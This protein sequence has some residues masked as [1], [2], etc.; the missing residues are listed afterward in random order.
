MTIQDISSL[1]IAIG[2]S[3]YQEL[4]RGNLSVSIADSIYNLSPVVK[5]SLTDSY[6][7]YL[8]SRIGN[9]GTP[10][11]LK[12]TAYGI[13]IEYPL[14][15]ESF[16]IT[17]SSET[18]K[19]LGGSY[20]AT[21]LH[22]FMF[23]SSEVKAYKNKSASSLISS[24]FSDFTFNG[25][26]YDYSSS[27]NLDMD[28]IYNPGYTPVE[29]IDKILLPLSSPTTDNINNPYYIFIDAQN[30]L[31]YISLNTMLQRGAVNTLEI[32]NLESFSSDDGKKKYSPKN[33]SLVA[34][35]APFSQMY[36][37]IFNMIDTVTCRVEN[38]EYSTVDSSLK[39]IAGS[40][41]PFYDRKKSL[42]RY[43]SDKDFQTTDEMMRLQAGI[44]YR[45]RASYMLD[46]IVVTT[47]LNLDLCAG[48]MVNLNSYFSN[49]GE[50]TAK[51]YT[52]KYLI[53]SSV[54][55]WDSGYNTGVSQLVLATPT[56]S[57]EQTSLEGH[58]YTGE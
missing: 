10:W 24:L 46:K 29:F 2:D 5:V 53:E 19:G 26:E 52:G 1:Q 41:M 9:Y 43:M 15:A 17:S 20:S 28:F 21:L 35:S 40:K 3:D 13:P 39:K 6:G 7:L 11:K 57:V 30:R 32:S 55:K 42:V 56:P 58:V 47:L 45:N 25:S 4:D 38:G 27:S 50:T 12:L 49:L 44:N 36:S 48:T 8:G 16:E 34:V 23:Q 18:G 14:K 22:E 31:K 37:R 54:H 33:N 51:A